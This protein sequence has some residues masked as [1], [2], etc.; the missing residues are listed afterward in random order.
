MMKDVF[1]LTLI[2]CALVACDDDSTSDSDDDS[3]VYE[4]SAIVEDGNLEDARTDGAAPAD[5]ETDA[6]TDAG[7]SDA[8]SDAETDAGESDA[9]PDAEPDA[10]VIETC[11]LNQ[12]YDPLAGDLQTSFPD[13][14]YTTEDDFTKTGL[15]VKLDSSEALWVAN[16]TP[17]IFRNIFAALND[18]DGFGTTAPIFLRFDG[19]VELPEFSEFPVEGIELWSLGDSPESLDYSMNYFKGE[20]S[21]AIW[22]I[23]PLKPGTLHAVLVTHKV[24]DA[25]QNEI[26]PSVTMRKLLSGESTDPRLSRLHDRYARMLS[27]TNYKADEIS[28]AVAFTTQTLFEK[29][30]EIAQTIENRDYTWATAPVCE[31]A[32]EGRRCQGSFKAIDFRG[33][34]GSTSLATPFKEY[35]IPFEIVLPVLSEEVTAPYTTVVV[36]H[37]LGQDRTLARKVHTHLAGQLKMAT[38]AIDSPYH[39]DHPG[40]VPEGEGTEREVNQ[41]LGFFGVP[42]P[43]DI[44]N[45]KLDPKKARGNLDQAAFDKLQFWRLLQQNSDIDGDGNPDLDWDRTAY[46]G[47]SLGGILGPQFLSLASGMRAA[48]LGVSGAH[49]SE[50]AYMHP[51]LQQEKYAGYVNVVFN[52]RIYSDASF[53]RTLAAL[54][55]VID[56]AEPLNY[57]DHLQSERFDETV[58]PHLLLISALDDQLVPNVSTNALVRT[59]KVPLVLPKQREISRVEELEAPVSGNGPDELTGGLFQLHRVTRNGTEVDATHVNV[60]YSQEACRIFQDFMGGIID[61][62][63]PAIQNPFRDVEDAGEDD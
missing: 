8:E 23:R 47:V 11:P 36:G 30:L 14:F 24:K 52:P 45:L 10:E 60:L 37:G 57:A 2:A 44:I 34:D 28:A 55:M 19:E 26:C 56:D 6:E 35:E 27:A 5:A 39:G 12:L 15:K 61:G 22:P 62:Q 3:S 16:S 29:K 1:G 31:E 13:D 21:I 54:Q 7:E 40:G 49:L 4:D 41:L 18:L 43:F 48:E 59:L 51:V 17:S 33:E 58:G 20:H 46:V 42:V 50:L 38:V 53:L 9:E 63:T 32:T 25:E